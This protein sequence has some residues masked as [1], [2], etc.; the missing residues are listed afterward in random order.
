MVMKRWLETLR[1][2]ITD[3]A[4]KVVLKGALAD[5]DRKDTPK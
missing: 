1:F 2:R 4:V 3:A 5:N